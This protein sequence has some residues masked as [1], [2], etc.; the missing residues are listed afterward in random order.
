VEQ[1]TCTSVIDKHNITNVSAQTEDVPGPAVTVM[2]MNL[3]TLTSA[4]VAITVSVAPNIKL[5][6]TYLNNK[7]SII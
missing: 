2:D 4:A 1:T 7:I 3:T 6:L 5:S